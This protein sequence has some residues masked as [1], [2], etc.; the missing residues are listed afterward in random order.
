MRVFQK[1]S[2][3]SKSLAWWITSTIIKDIGRGVKAVAAFCGISL[4][5]I[6]ACIGAAI[7]AALFIGLL[8]CLIGAATVYVDHKFSIGLLT[9]PG[10]PP[11]NL[12]WR[13]KIKIYTSIGAFS[14]VFIGM[15]AFCVGLLSEILHQIRCAIHLYSMSFKKRLRIEAEKKE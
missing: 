13:E 5:A 6:A 3:N 14:G 11:I 7:A 9:E 1:R 2:T 4:F 8:T 10:L 15:A 12:P